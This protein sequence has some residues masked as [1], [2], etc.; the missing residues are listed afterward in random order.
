MNIEEIIELHKECTYNKDELMRIESLGM[1]CSCFYCG[2]RF[3]PK[4][5]KEWTDKGQTAICP[6]CGIDSVITSCIQDED[7][8]MLHKYYFEEK[9]RFEE[10]NS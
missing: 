7:L 8:E 9:E 1:D 4:E 6:H 2:K 10:N 3:N 5:I